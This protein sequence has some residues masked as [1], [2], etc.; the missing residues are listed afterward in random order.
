MSALTISNATDFYQRHESKLILVVIILISTYLLAFAAKLTWSLLPLEQPTEASSIN[1]NRQSSAIN[2]SN[3]T[4]IDNIVDLNLFGN[5]AYKP[6]KT[7]AEEDVTDAPE[8]S[9]DLVLSGVVSSTDPDRG[10]AVIAYRNIQGTYAVGDKIEGTNVTLD[11]IY[12]DRVIIKNRLTRETLMLDGIDFEEAN[13]KRVQNA[14]QNQSQ[15]NT[16]RNLLAQ[17][18]D[19][20]NQA[21]ALRQARQKLAQEPA[22]FTDMISLAPHRVDGQLIGFRVTPGAKPAL[23]NSVGLKSGDIV[24]QLNGLDLTNLQQSS[25]AITQLREADSLQLEVLRNGEYLSLDLDIPESSDNE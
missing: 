17:N 24:I 5:A 7:E 10:A 20:R 23:F 1:P 8:T 4:N 25:E 16:P 3:D 22:S 15:V 14:N 6:V 12:V 21:Q 19:T 11:E 13:K 2:A 9:L 18:Q